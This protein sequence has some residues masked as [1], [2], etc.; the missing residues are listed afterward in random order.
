MAK[1]R[2]VAM[3]GFVGKLGNIVGRRNTAGGYVASS[4][5]PD[6]KNPR[7]AAQRGQRGKF[8]LAAKIT[9]AVGAEA[10][11]SLAS[12]NLMRRSALMA[13]IIS[14]SQ[15]VTVGQQSVAQIAAGLVRLNRGGL[16]AGTLIEETPTPA[17]DESGVLGLGN[18]TIVRV[19]GDA[20]GVLVTMLAV[21]ATERNLL[22]AVEMRAVTE[23]ATFDN[24]GAATPTMQL[25]VPDPEIEYTVFVYATPW[26]YATATS[27]VSYGN[28]STA[29]SSDISGSVAVSESGSLIYG[30]SQLVWS[31]NVQRG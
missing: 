21:P 20:D 4:Y 27:G 22:L 31:G 25:V 17:I 5:Q 6:I 14:R 30:D 2:S 13:D 7:T 26:A 8:A 18:A 15:L 19:G 16:V 10:I 3:S 1:M 11:P 28:A 23:T 12:S 9:A 29:G 24:S